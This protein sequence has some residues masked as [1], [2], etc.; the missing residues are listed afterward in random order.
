MHLFR[1]ETY[2]I[3]EHIISNKASNFLLTQVR[4]MDGIPLVLDQTS[5]DARNPCILSSLI[6]PISK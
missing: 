4:E 1:Q 5:I 3:I 6:S 2:L